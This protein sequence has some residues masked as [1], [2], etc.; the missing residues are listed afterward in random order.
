MSTQ[1]LPQSGATLHSGTFSPSYF[2]AIEA[3]FVGKSSLVL[4]SADGAWRSK[5]DE[6][7]SSLARFQI[8]AK[9]A[10]LVLATSGSTQGFKW[11]LLS[12][13][14]IAHVLESL[15]NVL[16]LKASD[17]LAVTAPAFHCF[18]TVV[19]MLL[20]RHVGC[21]FSVLP[22]YSARQWMHLIDREQCTHL[23]GVPTVF[24]DLLDILSAPGFQG[25][26]GPRRVLGSLRGGIIAGAPVSKK[27]F[28]L[29]KQNLGLPELTIGYGLTECSPAVT[30]T[31]IGFELKNDFEV[32][33]PI[34]GTRIRIAA[35]GEAWIQGPQLAYATSI[36][37]EVS[38]IHEVRTGDLLK[39]DGR[40]GWTFAGRTAEILNQGGEK[41][42]LLEVDQML[43]VRFEGSGSQFLAY[44]AKDERLGQR[45]GV[46]VLGSAPSD[47]QISKAILER[48][49]KFFSA[50]VIHRVLEF[51]RLPSGKVT[52]HFEAGTNTLEGA[53]HERTA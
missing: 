51:N 9:Q 53:L 10:P 1:R 28:D 20:A 15:A 52:R 26:G 21:R 3:A 23:L 34:P 4:T 42:S 11:V 24:Q 36:N 29:S 18:G 25:A 31:P 33:M 14:G 47:A 39:S 17:H 12:R 27:L 8:T 43:C 19:G 5:L 32:G 22:R 49:G 2:E 37:G 30:H 44:C 7:D 40:D 6:L 46:A 41:L 50:C 45:L 35:D 16:S 38:R 13:E 48:F